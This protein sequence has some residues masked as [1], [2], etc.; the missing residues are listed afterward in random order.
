MKPDLPNKVFW[1]LLLA[2]AAWGWV[3]L[4]T[5]DHPLGSDWGHYFTA[6]EYIWMPT[7][8]LAYP[9]F[10][11]PWFGWI[12]GG[13]GSWLGY[14]DAAQCLGRMAMVT[15][16]GSAA[17]LGS[18]LANR[19]AGLASAAVVPLMPLVMD[20]ALWVNHYPLLGAL[21]GAGIALSAA[22]AR[23]PGV[24]LVLSAG[25]TCGAAMAI[26]TRGTIAVVVG[27]LLVVLG[28][29]GLGLRRT[30]IRVI[31]FASMV[32]ATWAHDGWLQDSFNVPQLEFAQQL[33]VQRKGTLEQIQRGMFDDARLEAACE[34]VEPKAFSIDSGWTSCGVALRT[35]SHTRLH[36]LALLPGVLTLWAL[37]IV[38]LPATNWTRWGRVRSVLASAV[39][40]GGP[41][42]SLWLGMAWVTYFDRYVL[43]FAALMAA[44]VPIGMS[45]LLGLFGGLLGRF[46]KLIPMAAALVATGWALMQWPG[47]GARDLASP[48]S[49]R[50]SEYHAGVLARWVRDE[51]KSNDHVIDCAGLALDSLLLPMRIDYIRFPP[52]DSQC[53]KLLAEPGTFAGRTF[54]ITMHRD[55]PPQYRPTDLP[56]NA[57]AVAELG[58][59]EVDHSL[60]L[61]GYRVWEMK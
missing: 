24:V 59:T 57:A 37:L 11:K 23:W 52:G 6:A 19:W 35:S 20:G 2:V 13:L 48:E 40:F 54:L 5:I 8:G 17:L 16:I 30:A 29:V 22:A 43:P 9:D 61:E 15:M 34:G 33:Q 45:R 47:V 42:L 56:F 60:P 58:W 4:P 31:I 46:S 7:E 18:A 41:A 44:L 25:L 51:T 38:F 55:I 14:L 50:S 3:T 26:D 10:R 12:L 28:G 1:P 39:V 21:V 49:V 27:S 32:G 36:S 53:V